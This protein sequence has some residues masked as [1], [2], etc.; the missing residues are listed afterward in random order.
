MRQLLLTLFSISF[1]IHLEAQ[2]DAFSYQAIVRDNSG[3]LITN[4]NVSFEISILQTEITNLPVYT[5]THDGTTSS[6]G[7]ISLQIGRE[8]L[9]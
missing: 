7:G 4:S 9:F 6:H 8:I 5:E 1:L 2:N 3:I